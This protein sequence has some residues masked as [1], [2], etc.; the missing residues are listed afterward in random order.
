M[1]TVLYGDNNFDIARAVNAKVASFDGHP[2]RID[3]QALE[4]RQL[5]DIFMG[6]TLFAANRLV[7]IRGLSENKACWEALP[8]WLSRASD[9]TTVLLVEEKLDKRT[10]TYKALQKQA[11]VHEYKVWGERDMHLAEKWVVNEA[12][13]LGFALDNKS[14]RLLVQRVGLDNWALYR[15]LEKLSVLDSIAPAL[16]EQYIDIN[17]ADSVFNLF[18]A[19]LGHQP[20]KVREMLAVFQLSEDPYKLFGLLCGQVFQLAALVAGDKTSGE[21]AGDIGAHPFAVGKMASYAKKRGRSGVRSIV[22]AFVEADHGMKTS[23]AE[24]WILIERALIKTAAQ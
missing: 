7:I 16:V 15:A 22:A 20:E 5:P 17:P 9:D 14:A 8:M 4:L 18:E 21:V 1:I 24:P 12:E 13:S 19:A 6:R 11:T 10:K 23:S 2:E 3:G